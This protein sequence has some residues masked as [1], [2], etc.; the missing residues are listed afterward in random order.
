LIIRLGAIGDVVR[1]LPVLAV[2]RNNFPSA[3]IAW[4]VEQRSSEILRGQAEVNEV[5]VFPRETLK[6]GLVKG[7][8]WTVGREVSR[9]VR[10]LRR[11]RYDLVIDF[12]GILKSGLLSWV[13]GAR[14]RVGF[15]RGFSKEWNH[16]F[17]NWRVALPNLRVSR[18]ARNLQLL[19]GVGLDTKDHR[20]SLTV[21]PE[22][23]EYADGFL[24]EHGLFARYPLVAMHPG[25]SEKT[26]YKRWFLDRYARVAD[27]LVNELGAAIVVTWGPGERETAEKLQSLMTSPCVVSCPTESL[28]QLAGIYQRCHLYV[29]GDTGPLHIASL[30]GVPAVVVYGPTDPVVNAPYHGTP[31]TQ[32]KK[33]LSCSPCRDRAC[34]RVDCLKEVGHQDVLRAATALLVRIKEAS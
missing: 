2:L 31:S 5:I 34:Q 22:E 18:F 4:V 20:F 15:D 28:K 10:G 21:P 17:N 30:V 3:R 16:L 8:V 32:V 19:E 9:F 33:N 7:R 23:S 27:G 29:G 14:I 11:G 12:H 13:T 24:R 26:R 1:T 25:T 6:D